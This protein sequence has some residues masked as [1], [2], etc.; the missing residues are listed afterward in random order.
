[1]RIFL[2][3]TVQSTVQYSF[4]TLTVASIDFF[5]LL[6]GLTLKLPS[7]LEHGTGAIVQVYTAMTS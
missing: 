4:D 2:K 7:I 6:H 1:M 3:L 5:L